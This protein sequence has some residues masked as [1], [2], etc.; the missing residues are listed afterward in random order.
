MVYGGKV[1]ET[2][3]TEAVATHEAADI[4]PLCPVPSASSVRIFQDR[5]TFKYVNPGALLGPNQV[6]ARPEPYKLSAVAYIAATILE[7][8]IGSSL[9]DCE[10]AILGYA[11]L[12]ALV[13]SKAGSASHDGG[14]FFG[15]VLTTPDDLDS[16]IIAEGENL[17]YSLD[18]SAKLNS[19]AVQNRNTA[20]IGFSVIEAMHTAATY[21]PLRTGD[22]VAIGPLFTQ[23]VPLKP[24]DVFHL[25]IETL[26]AIS[27]G[28]SVI[29][30]K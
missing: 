3:G 29:G 17:V 27:V 11:P 12:I 21:G 9:E 2:D 23:P 14:L 20:D 7:A 26:G 15:P 10:A 24:G 30:E 28:L 13:N 16:C 18:A 1:F 6:V 25:S 22:I 8:E 5:E 19:T 4:R